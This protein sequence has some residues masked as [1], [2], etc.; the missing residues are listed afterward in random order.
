MFALPTARVKPLHDVDLKPLNTLAI[1]AS[2]T[3][4]FKLTELKE[5]PDLF[6]QVQ[7]LAQ[8]RVLG[9]GSNLLITHDQAKPIVKIE[10]L[11]VRQMS[12]TLLQQTKQPES[13]SPHDDVIIEA[14]AG[15]PWHSFVLHCLQQG[16]HGLENLSL[17]PGTVG[18]SPIQNIGAYGVEVQER[19]HSLV[20]WNWRSNET[21]EFTNEQC[22]FAY[23]DSFFKQAR[24][25]DWIVLAVR[26]A[27]HRSLDVK[28]NYADLKAKLGSNPTPIEVSQAVCAIRQ[29]KLPDPQ[30][31]PNA[32]SFFKNP[33]VSQ[34]TLETIQNRVATPVPHWKQSH[35]TVKLSAAWL[36]DQAGWKGF[37]VGDAGVHQHHAL[38][39][40][41][42][43]NATGKQIANLAADIRADIEKKFGITIEQEPIL[44][45]E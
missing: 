9:G 45:A 18:A 22:E 5:L 13:Q 32:G 31:L 37:R 30:K 42:Y 43:A 20:A 16:W 11:G 26:F 29:S 38:V 40:V 19:I 25:Q 35:F 41:N 27:L 28:T 12:P 39:L 33:V 7:G 3:T 10:L 23:R 24:G 1:K 14:M 44:W 34:Q 8:I 15:E 17:I 36:I 4:L 2:A 6:R 21:R